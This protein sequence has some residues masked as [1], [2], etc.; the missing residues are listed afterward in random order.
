[1]QD[2]H[3]VYLDDL[4]IYQKYDPAGMLTHIHNFP[5]LCRQA[6][7]MALNIKLPDEYQSVKKII[8]LGM[9]GSAI[10]GDLVGS[11]AVNQSTV[12]V[13]VC[14][15]YTLPRQVD[16]QTL[17]IASSYSGMTEETLA[18]FE[19]ACKT[20]A[21]KMAITTGG[22]L[23]VLCDSLGIPVFT[24]DYKTSPRAALPFSFFTL[25]GILHNL[26]FRPQKKAE[27]DETLAVLDDLNQQIRET[28]RLEVNPAKSLARDIYGHLPVIYGAGITAEVAHRWK[29][30]INENAKTL[31]FYEVFSELNH[32]A[33]VGYLFPEDLR[34]KSLIVILDSDLLPERLRLRIEITRELLE[35][36]GLQYQVLKGQGQSALSQMMSLILF[37]DYV[38]YYLAILN[39]TDPTEVKSI[40]FLK[41]SLAKHS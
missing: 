23:K 41:N 37:G 38:S 31:C 14:R 7:Q 32:N 12:G 28:C 3:T 9:G 27:I 35:K 33:V 21:L 25:L 34:P 10:G 22:K 26:G 40:D 5:D 17:V 6:W 19:Q 11:L 36:A 20:P 8:V 2:N 24:F 15:E 1:M 4:K 39:Q 13:Q 29:T 30:Q 18:A 16:E